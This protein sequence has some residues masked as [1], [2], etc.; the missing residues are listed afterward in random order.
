MSWVVLLK[1][2]YFCVKGNAG[3][4][5]GGRACVSAGLGAE[6]AENPEPGLSER[7]KRQSVGC[8]LGPKARIKRAGVRKTS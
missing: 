5:P 4:S 8:F 3:L 1:L 6:R 7:A 2:L